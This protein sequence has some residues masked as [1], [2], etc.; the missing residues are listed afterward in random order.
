MS[1]LDLGNSSCNMIKHITQLEVYDM[2]LAE[3]FSSIFK[4]KT[5]TKLTRKSTQI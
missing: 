2:K 4:K 1:V 5:T 3:D